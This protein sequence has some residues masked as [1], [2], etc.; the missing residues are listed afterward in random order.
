MVAPVTAADAAARPS[1][2][3][4]SV[5]RSENCGGSEPNRPPPRRVRGFRAPVRKDPGKCYRGSAYAEREPAMTG[6]HFGIIPRRTA[7]LRL[8]GRPHAILD[9]IAVH[10]DRRTGL[11]RVGVEAIA[12]ET[13]IHKRKVP[14]CIKYYLIDTG[15]LEIVERGGGG[16]GGRGR[17]NTYRIISDQEA[18]SRE[19]QSATE[20][21]SAVAQNGAVSDPQNAAA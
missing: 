10:T 4:S 15:I 7:G 21:A 8:P 16:V 11:A 20:A 19:T 6:P 5:E 14:D 1:T 17:A 3:A 2:D 9:V 13:G 18:L 12:R